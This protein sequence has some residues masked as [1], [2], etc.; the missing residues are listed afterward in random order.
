[1]PLCVPLYSSVSVIPVFYFDSVPLPSLLCFVFTPFVFPYVCCFLVTLPLC[2]S[3]SCLPPLCLQSYDHLLCYSCC[4]SLLFFLL[5][6]C[7]PLCL[8]PLYLCVLLALVLL[9]C[10]SLFFVLFFFLCFSS[11]CI[12]W[13]LCL[14]TSVSTPVSLSTFVPI[15]FCVYLPLCLSTSVSLYLCVPAALVW[16][17]YLCQAM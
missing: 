11:T 6:F 5:H 1:M 7:A 14:S 2:L 13:P 9:L 17:V 15:Y 8:V 3:V 4:V 12:S 16:F 10:Y